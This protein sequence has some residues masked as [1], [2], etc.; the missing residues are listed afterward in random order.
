MQ[1]KIWQNF[2]VCI[3]RVS[4]PHYPTCRYK[5]YI[6]L[7]VG[8]QGGQQ[9]PILHVC[10]MLTFV[11][12]VLHLFTLQFLFLPLYTLSFFIRH[13]VGVGKCSHETTRKKKKKKE[14]KIH[15]NVGICRY[16]V[17]LLLP[18]LTCRCCKLLE[19]LL[20]SRSRF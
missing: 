13:V 15:F 19:S 18:F 9:H 7:H 5:T 8:G 10:I 20:F 14:K 11:Y 16:N 6:R 12:I 3:L 4:S 1:N 2:C 17:Y